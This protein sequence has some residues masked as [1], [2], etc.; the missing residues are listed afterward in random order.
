MLREL[1]EDGLMSRKSHLEVFRVV[2][3]R[4]RGE[5]ILGRGKTA[6]GTYGKGYSS[7]KSAVNSH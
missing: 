7:G 5:G 6:V 4:D 1:R 3:G 2:M